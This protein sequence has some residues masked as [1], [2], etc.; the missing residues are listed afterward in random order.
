MQFNSFP[1]LQVQARDPSGFS[2]LQIYKKLAVLRKL[3]TFATG[4]L[5]YAVVNKNIFSFFRFSSVSHH[6]AYLVAINVGDEVSVDNYREYPGDFPPKKV[7][8]PYRGYVVHNT[9]SGESSGLSPTSVIHFEK[10][11]LYPGEGVVIRFWPDQV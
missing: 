6:P 10:I 8:V 3:A 1:F 5:D 11:T 2:T 9:G 7:F 4:G